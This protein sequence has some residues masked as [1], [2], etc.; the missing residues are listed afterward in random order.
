MNEA[1]ERITE[2]EKVSDQV[3]RE[4]VRYWNEK[5]RQEDNPQNRAL[6]RIAFELLK[7]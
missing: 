4:I 7:T 6:R 1:L 3:E 5:V 2:S